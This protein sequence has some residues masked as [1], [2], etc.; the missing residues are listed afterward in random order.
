MESFLNIKN[1]I[2]EVEN[3]ANEK[4]VMILVGNKEDL[5]NA[6]YSWINYKRIFEKGDLGRC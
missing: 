6:R 5:H 1:W 4:I 3:Y 2:T